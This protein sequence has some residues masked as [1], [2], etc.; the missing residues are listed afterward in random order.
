MQTVNSAQ[1]IETV[2]SSLGSDSAREMR[3]STAAD[4]LREALRLRAPKR[5]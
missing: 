3:A 2:E 1:L 5:K 4:E